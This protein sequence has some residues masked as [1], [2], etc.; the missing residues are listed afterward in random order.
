MMPPTAPALVV[1]QDDGATWVLN[2]AHILTVVFLPGE[3]ASDG[4]RIAP[5]SVEITFTDAVADWEFDRRLMK[6]DGEGELAQ[7]RDQLG[8]L[9]RRIGSD[10]W[11][12]PVTAATSPRR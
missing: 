7:I 5:E 3:V 1:R 10:Y 2:W 8:D 9:T 11:G 4:R 6:F 12:R